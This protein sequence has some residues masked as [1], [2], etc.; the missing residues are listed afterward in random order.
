MRNRLGPL[1]IALIAVSLGGASLRW[2]IEP[3]VDPLDRIAFLQA[4]RLAAERSLPFAHL[5]LAGAGVALLL[6]ERWPTRVAGGLL[7]FTSGLLINLPGVFWMSGLVI[8]VPLL[9]V[10][11]ALD[12]FNRGE[13]PD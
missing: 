12:R 6:A 13:D 11:L 5:A 10:A 2:F 8:S 4:E 7:V 1:A 3:P 9:F